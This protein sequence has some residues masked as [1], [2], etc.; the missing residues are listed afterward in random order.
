MKPGINLFNSLVI[1]LII[2]VCG[3]ILVSYGWIAYSIIINRAGLHG[4]LYWYYGVDK[5]LFTLYQLGIALSAL[6]IIVRLLYFSLLENFQKIKRTYLQFF[7]LLIVLVFC[8]LY[9]NSI[10]VGKG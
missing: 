3:F 2:V 7:V 4:N 10:Y 1:T 9:L 8:E 5:T 6:Y